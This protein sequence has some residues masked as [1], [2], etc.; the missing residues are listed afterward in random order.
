MFCLSMSQ[1]WPWVK[2]TKSS[3]SAFSQTYTFFTQISK[4][5]LKRFWRAKIGLSY[6]VSSMTAYGLAISGAMAPVIIDLVTLEYFDL[7]TSKA[8]PPYEWTGDLEYPL[9]IPTIYYNWHAS[10]SPYI[11]PPPPPPRNIVHSDTSS[12]G[13][14]IIK[15]QWKH[16]PQW[17]LSNIWAERITVNAVYFHI[18]RTQFLIS[19]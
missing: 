1:P 17:I 13:A 2:V 15:Q 14:I 7:S 19:I 6:I 11:T 10:I 3:S 9:I 8:T 16:V 12:F 18:T 4:V 5:K